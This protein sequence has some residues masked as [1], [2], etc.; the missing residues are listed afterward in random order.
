MDRPAAAAH[1]PV[2]PTCRARPRRGACQRT[3]A[4]P[5][6]Q[7]D[8]DP[9]RALAMRVA[10]LVPVPDYRPD[11]RGTYDAQAEA[12]EAAGIEVEPIMWLDADEASGFDLILPLV[13]WGYHQRYREWLQLLDT[14]E[15]RCA[16]VANPVPLLRWNSDKSYLE[17]L[18]ERGFASVPS[19]TVSDL[20]E[21]HLEAAR[22]HFGC[23]SLVVKP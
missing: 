9:A 20:D 1:R 13:A 4:R 12:L 22:A 18:G 3:D 14:L 17:E 6:R 15:C 5:D 8:S 19:M 11:W 23:D 10:F 16:P 7:P 2:P 21:P